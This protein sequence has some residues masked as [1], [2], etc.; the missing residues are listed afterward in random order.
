VGFFT[1]L[2]FNLANAL[3]QTLVS[4]Q[5]RGRVMGIYAMTFFGFMPVGGLMAGA[6]AEKIGESPTVV[7]WAL[8]SLV[9]PS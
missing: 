9:L 1:I 4:D 8:L 7:I 5:L 3:V 6:L 2:I